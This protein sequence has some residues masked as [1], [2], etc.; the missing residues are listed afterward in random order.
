[1]RKVTLNNSFTDHLDNFNRSYDFNS[2]PYIENIS[3]SIYTEHINNLVALQ[4]SKITDIVISDGEEEIYSL[5]NLNG[6]ITYVNE[7]I[8]NNNQTTVS[9]QIKV[10]HNEVAE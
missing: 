7:S 8:S 10:T 1:M 9:V 2:E 4:K 5:H 3:M 6:K